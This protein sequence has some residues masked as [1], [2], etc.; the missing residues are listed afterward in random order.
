MMCGLLV[1]I[2]QQA[3]AVERS[4]KDF[5]MTLPSA[6]PVFDNFL[7]K[8]GSRFNLLVLQG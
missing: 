3:A 5:D 2:P 6:L 4:I 1:E 8:F 7:A